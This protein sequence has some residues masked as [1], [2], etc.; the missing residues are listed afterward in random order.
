MTNLAGHQTHG[1]DVGGAEKLVSTSKEFWNM[2]IKAA[3]LIH[4]KWDQ[5]IS[6]MYTDRISW[7][8]TNPKIQKKRWNDEK[9]EDRY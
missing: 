3:L 9:K 2:T 4:D 5:T 7:D 1:V 8:K 6:N